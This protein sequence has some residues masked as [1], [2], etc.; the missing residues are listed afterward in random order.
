MD[1]SAR[2]QPYKFF[3]DHQ[4]EHDILSKQQLAELA[5]FATEIHDSFL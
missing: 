5:E 2:W 3:G 4:W 1:L